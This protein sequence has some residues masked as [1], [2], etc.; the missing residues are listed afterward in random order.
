MKAVMRI[1][2]LITVLISGITVHG[3]MMPEMKSILDTAIVQARKYALNAHNVKWDSIQLEMYAQAMHAKSVKDLH[4]SLQF[5]LI[6]LKDRHGKFVEA[7]SKMPIATYPNDGGHTTHALT[8]NDTKFDF[9]ILEN[10]TR[11]IKLVSISPEANIQ[12]E[13]ALIR[14]AIDSLSKDDAQQWIIDLRNCTGG[15]MHAN[16]AGIGP[17][18]G[19]GL[20]GGIVDGKGSVKKL[21]E[22]HNGR[23]YDDKHLVADFPVSKDMRDSKIAVLVNKQTSGAGEIVAIALRGRK[24]TKFF[25]ETTAGDIVIT[26]TIRIAKDLDMTLSESLYHDRK[27][28]VYKYYIR[29]DAAISDDRIMDEA[30][31][32]LNTTIVKNSNPS[33][34]L[35]MN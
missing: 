11:Y 25:G 26:K 16:I 22:V 33:A 5:L 23:F 2:L 24:N 34:A 27:G 18:L 12:D 3:Q 35:S 4:G 13:A 8:Q 9:K 19:E 20:I 29:P 15:S 17:L 32:W 21:F 14:S 1:V 7:N 30:I 6:A 10:G 28:S 31:T